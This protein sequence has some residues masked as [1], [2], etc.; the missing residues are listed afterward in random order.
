MGSNINTFARQMSWKRV[1][2]HPSVGEQFR[3]GY[4]PG[5]MTAVRASLLR[6]EAGAGP[7]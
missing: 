4:G 6:V 2:E 7:G 5:M 3:H 1:L